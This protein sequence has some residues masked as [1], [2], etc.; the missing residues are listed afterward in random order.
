MVTPV[1]NNTFNG[2]VAFDAP[3]AYDTGLVQIPTNTLANMRLELMRRLGFAG[4]TNNPPPGMAELLNSFLQSAQDELYWGFQWRHLIRDFRMTLTIGQA[5][6]DI[7]LDGVDF[8]EF[9]RI[10]TVT[11]INGTQYS[12]PL[13]EGIP[14]EL[15]TGATSG[16]PYRYEA[17]QYLE[18]YP[19]PSSAYL[20]TVKGYCGLRRFTLDDDVC[21]LDFRL[22]FLWALA[23]AKAHYGQPDAGR[24]DLKVETLRRQLNGRAHGQTRYIPKGN[25]YPSPPRPVIV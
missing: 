25:D 16:I 19:P 4:M 13:L 10:Q 8:L 11:I 23:N 21:M 20:V 1:V 5:L 12:G 9:R 2:P 22:V 7:P 15:R 17:Q 24:Y 3:V 6:Y 18:F 14:D